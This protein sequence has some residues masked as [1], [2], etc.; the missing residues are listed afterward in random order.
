MLRLKSMR[1][2][3]M[4]CSVS[5][6]LLECLDIGSHLIS[7]LGSGSKREAVHEGSFRALAHL[8]HKAALLQ[9]VCLAWCFLRHKRASTYPSRSMPTAWTCQKSHLQDDAMLH[10]SGSRLLTFSRVSATWLLARPNSRPSAREYMGAAK[11]ATCSCSTSRV[12]W[13]AISCAPCVRRSSSLQRTGLPSEVRDF[14]SCG[15]S[16]GL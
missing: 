14:G 1:R 11:Q 15:D 13:D 10:H 12:H 4:S 2:V 16:T 8:P 7:R 3:R 5:L 6:S 9:N